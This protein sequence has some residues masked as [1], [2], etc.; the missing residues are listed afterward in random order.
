MKKLIS[1]S[2]CLLLILIANVTLAQENDVEKYF[3]EGI[4]L[5]DN[6]DYKGAVYQYE[7]ALKIDNTSLVV[8]YELGS[9]FYALKNY[10]KA[11]EHADYVLN[12][13]TNYMEEAYI[14][15]GSVL[16]LQGK[17]KESIAM[18]KDACKKFPSSHLMYYNLALTLYNSNGSVKEIEKTLQS[19]IACKSNHAS[20]HLLLGYLMHDQQKRV[21]ALLAF[22]RFLL[23]E[24]N[25]KRSANVYKLL[26]KLLKKGVDHVNDTTINI[27][28]GDLGKD[29]EFSAAELMISLLEA[30]KTLEENKG[31]SEM[32]LFTENTK[33]F[34]QVLG[35]LRK[36]Q[37]GY[38][39]NHYVALFNDM[40]M[41]NQ[42]TAFCYFI[43]QSSGDASVATWLA[44]HKSEID[45]LRTWQASYLTK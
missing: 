13:K 22:Y 1:Y 41:N 12:K 20:S 10:D 24:P 16:D 5:Y 37:K 25:G 23:L 11:I 18:Y 43:S 3:K 45:A 14:L 35:E 6:G 31:K 34:F 40:I 27:T 33:S 32:E 26:V 30:S 38:W 8:H 28:L 4:R 21:Q 19:A 39:W 29:D 2:L 42:N 17:P 15:K 36:D 7:Q 44:T 9:T